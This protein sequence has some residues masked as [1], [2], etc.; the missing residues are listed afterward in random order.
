MKIFQW[1]PSFSMR[2][3]G[4]TDRTDTTKIIVVFLK[5]SYAPKKL[6]F[7]HE[8]YLSILIILGTK[9]VY[10]PCSSLTG[11]SLQ[12]RKERRQQSKKWLIVT[13]LYETRAEKNYILKFIC[14]IYNQ[15]IPRTHRVAITTTRPLLLYK[16]KIAL[17][18]EKNIWNP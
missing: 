8:V 6:H 10:V 2:T 9:I 17:Y 1:E 18:S 5:F 14:T 3:D 11:K 12:Q 15:T 4:R 16:G 7:S 13:L